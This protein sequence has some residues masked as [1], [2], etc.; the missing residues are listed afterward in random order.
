MRLDELNG[1]IGS[2]VYRLFRAFHTQ[3]V[4]L[5]SVPISVVDHVPTRSGGMTTCL[6]VAAAIVL[7][8][9]W[10]DEE[11]FWKLDN[12]LIIVSLVC[13]FAKTSVL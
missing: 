8:L 13:M 2:N 10:L 9:E 11:C 6:S 12:D 1:C 3:I 4:L 7:H 5:Q